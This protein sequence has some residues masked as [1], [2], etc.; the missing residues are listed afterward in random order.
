M[1]G[2]DPESCWTTTP[3]KVHYKKMPPFDRAAW[4]RR[5]YTVRAFYPLDPALSILR[6]HDF[7]RQPSWLRSQLWL[8]LHLLYERYAR[9]IGI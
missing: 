7:R 4:F 3:R 2:I 5:V 6:R 1:E 8:R 9:K